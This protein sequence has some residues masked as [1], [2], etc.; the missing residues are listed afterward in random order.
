[1]DTVT[2]EVWERIEVGGGSYT[3]TKVGAA[4]AESSSDGCALLA[5]SKTRTQ[6]INGALIARNG[7]A[8]NPASETAPEKH[9]AIELGQYVTISAEPS[10]KMTFS[11][12]ESG[13]KD[14]RDEIT[15]LLAEAKRMLDPSPGVCKARGDLCD[16]NKTHARAKALT[17][18][19]TQGTK[20][21]TAQQHQEKDTEQQDR[22]G[23]KQWN[24]SNHTKKHARGN[25]ARK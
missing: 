16:N 25:S 7:R 12:E 8:E 14:T 3:R 13:Q 24:T 2:S 10:V 17:D 9:K 4:R 21:L 22:R 11:E 23:T 19:T 5:L 18:A 20:R 6:A 1:M 15:K